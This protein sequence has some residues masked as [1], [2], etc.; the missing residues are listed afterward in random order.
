MVYAQE[1]G[2]RRMVCS[3]SEDGGTCWTPMKPCG[4]DIVS[5]MP[6]TAILPT[7]DGRLVGLTNARDPESA[8]RLSNRIIRSYSGDNGLS[9][10]PPNRSPIFRRR[11]CANRG[12]SPPP[13]GRSGPACSGRTTG[14]IP[15]W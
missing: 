15:Q 1:P 6:W 2:S 9:W 8:E 12:C 5:V 7:G 13:T 10:T 4:G 14:N 3:L 11:I